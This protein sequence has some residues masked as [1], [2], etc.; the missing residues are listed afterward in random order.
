MNMMKTNLREEDIRGCYKDLGAS[1]LGVAEG[2]VRWT[3]YE[4]CT[5]DVDSC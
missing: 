5:W 4:K 1:Y 2:T 3:F